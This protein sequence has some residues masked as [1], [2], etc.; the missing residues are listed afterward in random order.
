MSGMED[1]SWAPV[2][3]DNEYI[4]RYRDLPV[5]TRCTDC[6]TALHWFERYSWYSAETRRIDD[7][8]YPCA[9]KRDRH[10]LEAP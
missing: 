7:I 6:G 5:L 4:S 3:P 1:Q 2:E 10:R 8:C 9:K